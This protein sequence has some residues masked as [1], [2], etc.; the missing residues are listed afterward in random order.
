M[1]PLGGSVE[2]HDEEYD[3]VIWIDSDEAC[4]RLK[5]TSDVEI[6]KRAVKFFK[7]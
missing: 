2:K 1:S 4:R 3:E 7:E 6:V 5:Y